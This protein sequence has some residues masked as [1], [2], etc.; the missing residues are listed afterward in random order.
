M[1]EQMQRFRGTVRQ[2]GRLLRGN[3]TAVNELLGRCIFYAAMGSNDYLNNYFMP[4]S[5]STSADYDPKTY[6]AL[7]IQDYS[8]QLTVRLGLLLGFSC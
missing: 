7:L 1:G 2:I 5:Y 4:D 3:Q 6:A 8:R